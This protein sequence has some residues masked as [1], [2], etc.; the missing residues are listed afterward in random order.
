MTT[1]RRE[2]LARRWNLSRE[3]VLVPAGLHVPIDGTDQPHDF[4]AHPEFVYLAGEGVPGAVVTFDPGEGWTL[5]A[6][7]ASQETRIWEGDGESL[8]ALRERSGI[9]RVRPSSELDGWLERRR[10]ESLALLGNHDIERQSRGY[11]V[12]SWNALELSEDESLSARLSEQLSEARRS[13]D[14]EEIRRM[15][16]A[17]DSSRAGHLMA[18]GIAKPGMTERR[19]AIE[20]E[21]EFFRN[22]ALRTASGSIV[23]SGTNGSILHIAPTNR[24]LREGDLVLID[25][26]AE[27]ENY[28]ADI[29]RTFPVGPRYQGIQRDLYELVLATQQA[30]IAGVRPQQQYRDLHLAAALQIASGLRDLGI[31]RG[32]PQD[33]FE[34]DAHAMFFPHGL[35]HMI[36]LSTHDAGGCL[37]GRDKSDRFGLKW[38]RSDLPLEPGYVVTIEPGIY[39]VK[40][41]LTDPAWREKYRED[42]NWELVDTMLEFGGIRIEDDVLVTETGAEVLSAAIPSSIAAIEEIRAEALARP[43]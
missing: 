40:A 4:H 41:L 9:D 2:S 13:K 33:L 26:A 32:D 25:A 38:L 1:A 30:A 19:V 42:V 6:P 10:G 15:R 37:A 8:D 12:T 14:A 35:G 11:S 43:S 21:A 22:G 28:A 36:G 27:F 29:T 20:L 31:L 23:G 34:R 5:F 16:A 39:F 7:V 17:V 3:L 24:V 18:M